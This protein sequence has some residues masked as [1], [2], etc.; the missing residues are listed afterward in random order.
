MDDTELR[1]CCGASDD[2][3]GVIRARYEFSMLQHGNAQ[4][5][6]II[7]WPLWDNWPG[8]YIDLLE[9]DITGFDEEVVLV[10][11]KT[12]PPSHLHVDIEE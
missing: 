12:T 8:G 5:A 4:E 11:G 7:N 10:P 2:D 3:I 1:V 9:F 6:S